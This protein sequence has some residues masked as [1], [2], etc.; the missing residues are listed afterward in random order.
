MNSART[1]DGHKDF[2]QV[3]DVCPIAVDGNTL[4]SPTTK[5][6]MK[7]F[8][9]ENNNT[10]EFLSMTGRGVSFSEIDQH[11]TNSQ[12]RSQ[13]TAAFPKISHWQHAIFNKIVHSRKKPK[14]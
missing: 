9:E 2:L 11:S 7:V 5:I 10:L 13:I 1:A 14:E 6:A 12:K 8:S 3:F 4:L